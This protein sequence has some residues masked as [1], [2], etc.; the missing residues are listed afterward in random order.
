[1]IYINKNKSERIEQGDIIAN[2]EYIEYA[3]E[4]AGLIK[5]SKIVFPLVIVLTQDCDLTWDYQ[6]RNKKKENDDEDKFLMSV[7][8]APLYNFEHFI[9]GTHLEDIGQ[10]MTKAFENVKKTNCKILKENN[11]PRYHFLEFDDTISIVNS[12]IDFKHYFTVNVNTLG[13]CKQENF[14]CSVAPIYRERISQR[15]A[16]YLSRIGLPG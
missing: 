6:N 1:M 3:E 5:V 2:V 14:V 10:T 12:V 15:F 11:N 9:H 4:S 8:V 16:N 13:R 7:I